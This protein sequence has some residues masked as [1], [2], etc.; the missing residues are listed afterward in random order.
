MERVTRAWRGGDAAAL[1]A[2]VRQGVADH[3]ELSPI[4]ER[5]ITERNRTM[6]AAIERMLAGNGRV[7]VVVGAAH[8]IDD[9]GLIHALHANGYAVTQR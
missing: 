6:L 3:P 7:F 5:L 4:T 9:D 1:G 2:I 8:L